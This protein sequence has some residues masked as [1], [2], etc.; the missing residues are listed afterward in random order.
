MKMQFGHSTLQQL[1]VES[2]R[3]I[4]QVG[5]PLIEFFKQFWQC[6]KSDFSLY[7]KQPVEFLITA[8]YFLER[9][10]LYFSKSSF[11]WWDFTVS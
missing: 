5:E 10:D 6:K 9:S 3:P 2:V 11:L 8:Y 4:R 1:T 7:R